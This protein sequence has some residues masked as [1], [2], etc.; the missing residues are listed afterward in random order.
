MSPVWGKA[1]AAVRALTTA[2]FS[3][4]ARVRRAAAQLTALRGRRTT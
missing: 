1:Q 3:A 4:E 2:G